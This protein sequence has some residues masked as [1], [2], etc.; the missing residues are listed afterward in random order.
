MND[1]PTASAS[2][3]A[4]PAAVVRR[5]GPGDATAVHAMLDLF[6][7]AFDDRATYASA[8][9]DAAYLARLL[10]DPTVVA[11]VALD[12]GTV[13]GGLVAYELR[14]LEQARSELY[15]YDLAVAAT[16]R[17]RG[18]ATALIGALRAVASERG[19]WVA[20]VQAD[21][22]DDAAIAL[23]AGLGAREDVLHFDIAVPPRSGG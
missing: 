8:R 11:M 23:Y 22:G 14:K 20:F 4:R 18:V 13:I 2:V 1:V 6:A 9:P 10:D 15:L 5:L 3:P 7:E 17:R 12:G 21:H 16:H 19:A